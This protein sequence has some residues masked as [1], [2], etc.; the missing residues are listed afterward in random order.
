MGA[1]SIRVLDTAF[2]LFAEIDDYESLQFT[3]RFYRAGEFELHIALDKQNVDQLVKDRVIYVGNQPHKA[4]IIQR[5][6][7]KTENGIETIIIRGP[8]IGGVLDRRVTV[9]ES[10]D[11]ISGPAETVIKHYVHRHIV[12]GLYP[13]RSIPFVSIAPNLSRGKITPWQSR[14]ESLHEVVQQVAEWCDIGWLMRLDFTAKKWVFDVLLGRDLTINQSVRP[15][16]IFSNEFENIDSQLF[17]DDDTNYKNVGY[18]AG[19]GEDEDRLIL[20]VGTGTGFNRREAFIDASSAEDAVELADIGTQQ[21]AELKRIT[22]FG[23]GILGTGGFRYEQ[24]WD[25]G[26][27]VT[28]QNKGWGLTMDARITEIKEIY[29]PVVKLE[30]RF[31]SEIP[32]ITRDVKRLQHNVKRRG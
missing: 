6:E 18:A 14:Y 9:T 28:L 20:M 27:V 32:T 25:L 4:G 1:P 29:E 30:V 3:R 5:R 19:P 10:Y 12:D 7:V 21:L 16:V 13:G 24:D 8:T 17:V 26:D 23:G 2:N 11:R 31:G 22:T 15:W